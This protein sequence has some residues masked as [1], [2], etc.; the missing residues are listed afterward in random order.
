MSLIQIAKCIPYLSICLFYNLLNNLRSQT[1]FFFFFNDPATTEIY[2]FPLPDPLPICS[3]T[4]SRR[5]PTRKS[6]CRP[7]A[8]GE[9]IVSAGSTGCSRSPFGMGCA[10]GCFAR[11][12]AW[13]SS[14]SITACLRSEEHTS[15]LQSQSNL[16]CRLLL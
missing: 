11:G 4:R 2:P 5:G 10:G 13:G 15:E 14:P 8:T 6:C 7:T 16:V 9:R 3:A 12:I 1:L